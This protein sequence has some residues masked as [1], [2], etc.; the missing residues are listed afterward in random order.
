VQRRAI[1]HGRGRGIEM[2]TLLKRISGQV[3]PKR[4]R[5]RLAC[6]LVLLLCACGVA[7]AWPHRKALKARVHFLAAETLIRGTWGTNQDKYLAEFLPAKNNP[8]GLL[9]IIDEYPQWD[10]PVSNKSLIAHEGSFLRLLRDTTCDVSYAELH[11]RA[12]PGDRLA[13]LP[14]HL[15]YHPDLSSSVNSED[16]VPCYHIVRRWKIYAQN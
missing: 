16:L 10:L 9:Q 6:C 12:A 3:C 2:L 1:L 7:Q 8:S 5:C 13:L 4:C 14:M 11:L 15:T